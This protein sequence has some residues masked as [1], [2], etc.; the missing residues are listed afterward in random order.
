VKNKSTLVRPVSAS[1]PLGTELV[2]IAA[3]W[4]D[5]Q[6]EM[7]IAA[8]AF[9]KSPEWILDG[10]PTPAH[11]LATV[12]GVEACTAREWIRIG[13]AL[14]QLPVTMAAFAQQRLTYSKVRP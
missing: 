8:A 1:G 6:F 5:C 10:L 14:T 4:A 12:A 7:V 3:T 9:A 11:W 2:A 13:K